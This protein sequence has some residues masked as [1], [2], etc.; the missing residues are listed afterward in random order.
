MA[1]R[2]SAAI[3]GW[4]AAV[5]MWVGA[6]RDVGSWDRAVRSQRTDA[7]GGLES[8]VARCNAPLYRVRLCVRPLESVAFRCTPR[9]N[10]VA[11]IGSSLQLDM[12]VHCDVADQL[13]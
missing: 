5:L 10:V 12:I 1:E 8:G 2:P 3:L 6:H 11:Y 9:E 7:L 4:G 13:Q